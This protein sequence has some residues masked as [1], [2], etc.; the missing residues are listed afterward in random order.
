MTHMAYHAASVLCCHANV[1][2]LFRLSLI[3][4]LWILGREQ[5]LA[6]VKF[7]D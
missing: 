4:I 2:R 6:S 3:E 5:S 7:W 1:V